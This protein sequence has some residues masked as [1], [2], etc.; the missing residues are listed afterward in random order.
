MQ[1]NKR[2]LP[3]TSPK[4]SYFLREFKGTTNSPHACASLPPTARL[5]EREND[6]MREGN[7]VWSANLVGK[8][9]I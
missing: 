8:S 4:V 9:F 6:R 1:Q 5:L 7:T 2:P 3:I